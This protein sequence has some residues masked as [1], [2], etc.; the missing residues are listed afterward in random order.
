MGNIFSISLSL[1]PIITRCWDCATGQASYICHLEDNLQALKNEV[2]ELKAIR[3]DLMSRVG[4]AEDEQQLKRLNQVEG[5]LSRA[6]TLINDADQLIV[7]SPQH[8]ENLCMGGC[9]ST[10]P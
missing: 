9:C 10:H 2:E 6:E 3:R 1:D 7:Q 4:I 8:V 5:W